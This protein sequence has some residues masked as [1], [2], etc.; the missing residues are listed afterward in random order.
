MR[1]K[2]GFDVVVFASISVSSVFHLVRQES[3][4]DLVG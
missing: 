3:F 4:V 2:N 1:A